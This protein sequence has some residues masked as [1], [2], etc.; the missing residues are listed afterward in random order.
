MERYVG[1]TSE[2]HSFCLEEQIV[3]VEEVSPTTI[4]KYLLHCQE[5][6]NN[7]TVTKNSKLRVLKTFFNYLAENE[8]ITP[9]QNATKKISYAK[10][11]VVIQVFSFIK[12]YCL[13]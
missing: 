2:F 11:D 3:N 13:S 12:S 7:N 10:E 8:F 6:R 1:T 9:Q 4:K 5:K